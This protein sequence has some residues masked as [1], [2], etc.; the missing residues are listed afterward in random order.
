MS[1]RPSDKWEKL[2]CRN[3]KAPD[4]RDLGGPRPS[5]TAREILESSQF[6]NLCVKHGVTPT[7]RQARKF[8]N[9]SSL[10]AKAVYG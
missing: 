4:L 7:L 2:Y 1:V 8:R 5:V 9:R 6:L 3:G 10:L